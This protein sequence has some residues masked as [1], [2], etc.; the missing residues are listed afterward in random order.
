MFE[1]WLNYLGLNKIPVLAGLLGA[2][3][4]LKFFPE[5]RLMEKSLTFVG[6]CAA[7]AYGTVPMVAYLAPSKPEVYY[8]GVG[9]MLGL[10]SMAIAAAVFTQIP[11]WVGMGRTLVEQ[12][13]SG[14]PK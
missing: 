13:R 7:A 1:T 5:L 6:G 10:F 12:M 9:F 14:G 3:V 4:S 8:G 11:V 2:L